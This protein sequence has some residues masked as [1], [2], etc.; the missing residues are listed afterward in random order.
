MSAIH[1]SISAEKIF[2]LGGFPV[3]NSIFTSLLV[4]TLLLLLALYL[5]PKLK[6]RRPTGLQNLVE[7]II[8]GFFNMT[9]SITQNRQKTLTIFPIV[10]TSFI[11]IM[12]NNYFGLLPGVN[13]IGFY[14][15]EAPPAHEVSLIKVVDA[16]EPVSSLAAP[17]T[18]SSVFVPLFRAATADLNTTLALAIFSIV[19]VQIIGVKYL[20]LSYFTKFFNFKGPIDFFVGFLETVSEIVKIVSFAFRLFGNIFAGEVLMAVM[21]F[22]IPL[23]VPVPFIGLEIFVGAV[24]AL[25]FALL[26]LVFM[27]M[28]TQGHGAEH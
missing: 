13:T 7:M 9:E 27:S 3:T 17:E 23:L 21:S 28:A 2:D 5:S 16:S 22:L 26:S 14:E 6:F 11:W 25:V 15:G 12:L 8:E 4:S 1:I 10:M 20:G 18:K 24:Q 19:S